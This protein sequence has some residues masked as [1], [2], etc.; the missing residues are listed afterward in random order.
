MAP[1]MQSR[2]QCRVRAD[3]IF[4]RSTRNSA[5]ALQT[6]LFVGPA[7]SGE[8]IYPAISPELLATWGIGVVAKLAWRRSSCRSN[9]AANDD[10]FRY[11]GHDGLRC[12]AQELQ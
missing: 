7:A 5:Q 12:C 9:H 11:R 1:C 4:R 3:L 6:Q 10:S 2:C 8:S